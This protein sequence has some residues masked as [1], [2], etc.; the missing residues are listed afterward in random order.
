MGR[1]RA[2]R[3]AGAVSGVYR[4]KEPV[5]PGSILSHTADILNDSERVR[6]SWS[7]PVP[8]STTGTRS[9][10]VVVGYRAAEGFRMSSPALAVRRRHPEASY[11]EFKAKASCFSATRMSITREPIT[12][13]TVPSRRSVQGFRPL[14]PALVR[15]SLRTRLQAQPVHRN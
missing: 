13:R 14:F 4:N 2:T 12:Q 1:P 15:R 10:A 7:S 8:V 11:G 9:A 3:R 6:P 5:Q